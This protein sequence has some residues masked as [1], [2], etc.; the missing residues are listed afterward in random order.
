MAGSRS[1]FIF[2]STISDGAGR[3]VDST[4]AGAGNQDVAETCFASRLREVQKFRQLAAGRLAARWRTVGS[5]NIPERCEVQ[6]ALFDRRAI[7]LAQA[8]DTAR[9]ALERDLTSRIDRLQRSQTLRQ[10]ARAA[11]RRACRIANR[12]SNRSEAIGRKAVRGLSGSLFSLQFLQER[13]SSA[14]AGEL[15]ESERESARR[16][17]R[18]IVSGLTAIGPASSVRAIFDLVA[19]PLLDLLG[20]KATAVDSL[21]SGLLSSPLRP[22]AARVG[23]LRRSSSSSLRGMPRSTAPGVTLSEPGSPQAPSGRSVRT[24]RTFESLTRAAPTHVGISSSISLFRSAM[25]RHSA[26]CG[27]CCASGRSGGWVAR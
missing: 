12:A 23:C 15:G 5:T 22:A 18:S 9:T 4:I 7:D 21:E 3:V 11:A 8:Y 16:R 6:P 14:L 17:A 20:F 26:C 2:R 24:A 27:A 1:L 25:P 10:A 19:A 13:L